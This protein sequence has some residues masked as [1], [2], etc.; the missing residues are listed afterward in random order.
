MRWMVANNFPLLIV[1]SQYC[2]KRCFFFLSP[3]VWREN[4]SVFMIFDEY[5]AIKESPSWFV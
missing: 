5:S 4:R 2:V 1:I 3:A